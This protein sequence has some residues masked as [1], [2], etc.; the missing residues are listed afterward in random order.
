MF[1]FS[2]NLL[3]KLIFKKVNFKSKIDYVFSSSPDLFTAFVGTIFAKSYHAKHILEIRDIWPLSQ[4]VHHNYSSMNPLI[5]LMS[6]IEHFLYRNSNLIISTCHNFDAY[7]KEKKYNTP[8]LFIPPLV[9]KYKIPKDKI[10]FDDLKSCEKVGIYAGTIGN[11]YELE[12]LVENF[13]KRLESKIGII[14]VGSGDAYDKISQLIVRN[15]SKNFV[16]LPQINH[17]ELSTYYN[18]SNF[19]IAKLP[20]ANDLYKYGVNQLKIPDYMYH[21][22]PILFIGN[23]NHICISNK[24]LIVCDKDDRHSYSQAFDKID[25]LSKYELKTMGEKNYSYV[26]KNFESSK[27]VSELI[28]MMNSL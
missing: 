1:Y 15:N 8:F 14:L 18:S 11:F 12:T 4:I 5:L 21:N 28:N 9:K 10:I 25:S 7:L 2:T 24:N 23:P 22:L 16:V 19:A 13:P 27:H 3:I 26:M 17:D 20:H 6:Q